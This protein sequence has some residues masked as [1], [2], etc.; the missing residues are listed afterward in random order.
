MAN[1][2]DY[3]L[4]VFGKTE[5]VE[6]FLKQMK[7]MYDFEEFDR[8]TFGGMIE[9][10][11][12][13]WCKWSVLSAM[14]NAGEFDL[15]EKSAEFSLAIEVFSQEP[16]CGFQEHY[17]SEHGR[18]LTDDCVDYEEWWIEGMADEDIKNL[19]EEK[20]FTME[21]LKN[22][23]NYNGDY[24]EGGF[25]DY[26]EFSDLSV[27]FENQLDEKITQAQDEIDVNERSEQDAVKDD[28][29]RI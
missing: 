10:R 29:G 4:K 16:G 13:G 22:L 28:V 14:R 12:E 27:Y 2:C 6:R 8:D 20:G 5:N 9:V 21:E 3:S 23:V 25:E 19:C 17:L 18:I 15:T 24:C 7:E 26:C 11:G 1:C